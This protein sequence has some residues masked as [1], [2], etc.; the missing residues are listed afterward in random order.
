MENKPHTHATIFGK[1]ISADCQ[2]IS[3]LYD[4]TR[5]TMVNDGI[6]PLW[7]INLANA[8]YAF[9]LYTLGMKPDRFFRTGDYYTYFGWSAKCRKHDEFLQWVSRFL[10]AI[11]NGEQ[12]QVLMTTKAPKNTQKT[13]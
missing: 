5:N 11:K 6:L 2:F 9:S 7:K 10:D 1:T 13:I 3:D 4:N 12:I 8:R